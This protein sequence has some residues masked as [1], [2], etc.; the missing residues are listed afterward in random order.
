MYLKGKFKIGQV[1][2]EALGYFTAV[3]LQMLLV[4]LLTVV[5]VLLHHQF[6]K[7]ASLIG[8]ASN[9]LLIY[10]TIQ[11]IL[12]IKS[13]R[14]DQP[15]SFGAIHHYAKGYFGKVIGAMFLLG[16]IML[17]LI[18]P[19]VLILMTG[20]INMAGSWIFNILITLL[21]MLFCFVNQGIVIGKK[22]ITQAL[23]H[24]MDIFF[25][26]FFGIILIG[27]VFFGLGYFRGWL[28][29]TFPSLGAELLAAVLS[30]PLQVISVS[31]YTVIFYHVTGFEP[32]QE[33]IETAF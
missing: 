33:V 23:G 18:I 28:L 1:L 5:H 14:E 24:S 8:I 17:F 26:N 25:H 7:Y 15:M 30:G 11:I 3:P 20:V 27:L 16:G 10:L 6:P 9:L 2:P 21:V 13:L 29:F 22:G 19:Y 4:S 32:E 31:L 12:R